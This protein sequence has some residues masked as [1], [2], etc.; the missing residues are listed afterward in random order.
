MFGLM[1]HADSMH[2]IIMS[3]QGGEMRELVT[4]WSVLDAYSRG[5]ICH[6]AAMRALHLNPGQEEVLL[7]AM[8]EAGHAKPRAIIGPIQTPPDD[9]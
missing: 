7:T 2:E 3:L 4:V 1:G 6:A 5:Q 8:E 9:R